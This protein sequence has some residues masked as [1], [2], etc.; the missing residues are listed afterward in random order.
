MNPSESAPP[1]QPSR[2][3]AV[4]AEYLE[5]QDRGE[6]VDRARLL[7]AHPELADALGSY[8]ADSDAL[9]RLAGAPDQDTWRSPPPSAPATPVAPAAPPRCVGDYE[10]LAEVARG[11]MG[12]VYQARQASL[13]RVVA[14][15]MV[16]SGPLASPGDAQRLRREAEAAAQLDHAHIVP[17]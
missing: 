15:K 10:L 12:V 14:L 8:F 5:R 6:P 9:Q 16:L 3:E 2:L 7:A 1:L 4:L 17:I 13:N 11:G